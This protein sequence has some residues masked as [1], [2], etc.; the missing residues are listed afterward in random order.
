MRH[1]PNKKFFKSVL[2]KPTITYCDTAASVPIICGM[3]LP[4]AAVNHSTPN[5]M[6]PGPI[7]TMFRMSISKVTTASS[8]SAF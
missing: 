4:V 6:K 1:S 8:V 3:L 5:F 7:H 2:A